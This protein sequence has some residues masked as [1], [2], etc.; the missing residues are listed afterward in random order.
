MK[1]QSPG[2]SKAMQVPHIR[3]QRLKSYLTLWESLRFWQHA[4]YKQQ[5]GSVESWATVLEASE[6]AYCISSADWITEHGHEPPWYPKETW[7][8]Q[9]TG[10]SVPFL[11]L[12][13]RLFWRQHNTEKWFIKINPRRFPGD[14]TSL[15]NLCRERFHLIIEHED[16]LYLST[17]INHSFHDDATVLCMFSNSLPLQDDNYSLWKRACALH[18]ELAFL[19]MLP[20]WKRTR[21]VA[22]LVSRLNAASA[23]LGLSQDIH[24]ELFSKTRPSDIAALSEERLQLLMGRRRMAGRLGDILHAHDVLNSSFPICSGDTIDRDY[25]NVLISSVVIALDCQSLAEILRNFPAGRTLLQAIETLVKYRPWTLAELIGERGASAVGIAGILQLPTTKYLLWDASS[26]ANL[27][28]ERDA[29]QDILRWHII[30]SNYPYYINEAVTLGFYDELQH[31][32]PKPR[33]TFCID[34]DEPPQPP[35]RKEEGPSLAPWQVALSLDPGPGEELIDISI[36]HLAE[37]PDVIITDLIFAMRIVEINQN[38]ECR[39]RLISAVVDAYLRILNKNHFGLDILLRYQPVLET[40]SKHLCEQSSKQQWQKWLSPCE[41]FATQL[42]L[43]ADESAIKTR[44]ELQNKFSIHLMILA[45]Q[46]PGLDEAAV[47]TVID[48]IFQ[49]FETEKKQKTTWSIFC[50]TNPIVKN[51]ADRDPVLVQLGRYIAKT[52]SKL[53]EVIA[54]FLVLEPNSLERAQLLWGLNPNGGEHA[55][56]LQ[57]GLCPL[58]EKELQA[59]E[60]VGYMWELLQSLHGAGEFN[61]TLVCVREFR[62]VIAKYKDHQLEG[63]YGNEILFYELASLIGLQR[64]SEAT[65]LTLPSFAGDIAHQCN[66]N[67]LMAI[68]WLYLQKYEAALENLDAVL[69]LDPSNSMALSNYTAVF[70]WRRDWQRTVDAAG[71]ARSILGEELPNAVVQNEILARHELNDRMGVARLLEQLPS[72]ADQNP[73]ILKIRTAVLL[74]AVADKSELETYLKLL[75]KTQPALAVTV[76]SQIEIAAQVHSFQLS[77]LAGLPRRRISLEN[78]LGQSPELYISKKLADYCMKLVERPDFAQVLNEDQLTMVIAWLM[79]ALIGF[80]FQMRLHP[81]GGHSVIK[82]GVADF[83][84]EELVFDGTETA[85]R[86]V[87]GEAKIW[88]GIEYVEDGLRQVF[89]TANTYQEI[90]LALVVY[91]K[92]AEF[93]ECVTKVGNCLSAF[94]GH[95]NGKALY[96]CTEH[97]ELNAYKGT[98]VRVFRSVHKVTEDGVGSYPHRVLY[99]YIIDLKTEEAKAVRAAK[100]KRA[101][102]KPERKGRTTV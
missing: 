79:N 64:Y 48:K 1:L 45:A 34:G 94:K 54:R 12:G 29:V 51:D 74:S 101:A 7:T 69:R 6:D 11:S 23:Q 20:S 4:R 93:G 95:H 72:A 55:A 91:V 44:L 5:P 32:L 59:G 28:E 71:R 22:A 99:S 76:R 58:V 62:T 61:A 96:Q 100:P 27:T 70:L 43:V 26:Q 57:E 8:A 3:Q 88:K 17:Q 67:N 86:L 31:S 40:F 98:P 39:T 60:S 83:S 92:S 68:A 65:A 37:S 35:R 52:K 16:M 49:A 75:E 42:P 18:C 21:L 14:K 97:V 47:E 81:E 2:F 15:L 63:H 87:T 24:G 50:W 30:T 38:V 82:D 9:T 19:E 78:R 56:L 77:T 13:P 90:F 36:K 53:A 41:D 84:I 33:A 46:V 85:K 66:L 102:A 25:Y 73:N 10:D 89:G 80:G